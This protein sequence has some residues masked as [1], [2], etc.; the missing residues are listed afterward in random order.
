MPVENTLIKK[1]F[2]FFSCFPIM[3]D[4]NEDLELGQHFLIDKKLLKKRFLKLTC[5]KKTKLLRLGPERAL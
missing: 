1:I 5:Q 4:T 3:E 2:I